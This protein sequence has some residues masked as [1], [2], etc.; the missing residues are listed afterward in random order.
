VAP[1]RGRTL[2]IILL[3]AGCSLDFTVRPQPVEG[4]VP[5]D[6]GPDADAPLDAAPD[7][8]DAGPDVEVDANDSGPDCLALADEVDS[9]RDA[10]R[11]CTLAAGHCQQTVKN[12]C[13]CDVVI[14]VP[15]SADVI[16]YQEA[17]DRLVKSGCPLG[18]PGVCPMTTPRNCLQNGTLVRCSP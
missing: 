12:Q 9:K 4:G 6:A 8:I 5:T 1:V 10:A 13:D 11:A 2:T 18:C 17:V 14:A 3:L 7:V 15:G 16:K